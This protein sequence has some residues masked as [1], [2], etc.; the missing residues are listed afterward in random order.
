[1]VIIICIK[2]VA[3]NNIVAMLIV[4]LFIL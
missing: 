4:L 2:M 1:M 3:F